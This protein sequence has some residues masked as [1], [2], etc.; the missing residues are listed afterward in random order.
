MNGYES[1]VKINKGKAQKEVIAILGNN[2]TESAVYNKI[3]DLS[4]KM[5]SIE[6]AELINNL[7]IKADFS[8]IDKESIGVIKN[9]WEHFKKNEAYIDTL[10]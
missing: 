8:G 10:F 9:A 4:E 5:N 3:Y 1:L 7:I 6:H 2:M